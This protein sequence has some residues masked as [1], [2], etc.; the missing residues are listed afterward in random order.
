ME[1]IKFLKSKKI[2]LVAVGVVI[3]AG[4]TGL[5]FYSQKL[6]T[7]TLVIN[8]T[9][10]LPFVSHEQARK[11]VCDKMKGQIFDEI[12]QKEFDGVGKND[13]EKIGAL[14]SLLQ[15][16]EKDR[17]IND[18]E[19]SL[20]AQAVFASLPT[21]DSPL[22]QSSE[23]SA[24]LSKLK[25]FIVRGN[26]AYAKESNNNL[27]MGEEKFKKAMMD[28]LQKM[29]NGLPREDN[30]WTLNV[31][32]SKYGWVNGVRQPIYSKVY[33][34]SY[35]PYPGTSLDTTVVPYDGA[36]IE[37]K[38]AYEQFLLNHV[39]SYIGAFATNQA[40]YSGPL[41]EGSGEMIAYSFSMASFY[42][43][44]YGSDSVLILAEAG[45]PEY[46]YNNTHNFS[47]ANYE[48][49]DLLANLLS[50][51]QMPPRERSVKDQQEKSK[52]QNDSEGL[53]QIGGYAEVDCLEITKKAIR[54]DA[55]DVKTDNWTAEKGILTTKDGDYCLLTNTYY[56]YADGDGNYSP[57]NERLEV[58]FTGE[59]DLFGEKLLQELR[60]AQDP[61]FINLDDDSN[62]RYERTMIWGKTVR[63]G[64]N[65]FRDAKSI[66]T[67]CVV[68]YSIEVTVPPVPEHVTVSEYLDSFS[69]GPG[70]IPYRSYDDLELHQALRPVCDI[71]FMKPSN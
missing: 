23:F 56:G 31:T 59:S 9:Q 40:M 44:P 20:L 48:G 66:F 19:R 36:V 15:K 58:T 65:Y 13:A 34:S 46:D 2:L 21:K 61:E 32:V 39:Q 12:C 64:S 37:S 5:Y 49:D 17:G 38:S 41:T 54:K 29:T 43:K 69:R 71:F 11:T 22:A 52:S 70:I 18:Y 45:P 62:E 1:Y 42:S 30:A 28:D 60:A 25:N 33:M 67:S 51:V 10:L 63:L 8:P 68:N 24:T 7:Y 53:S 3:V 14:F 35:N 55:W 26:V 47:E 27:G 16:I 4:I 57:L 6:P 50:G